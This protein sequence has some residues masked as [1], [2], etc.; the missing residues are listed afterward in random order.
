MEGTAGSD[1]FIRKI[2]RIR[3]ISVVAMLTEKQDRAVA[4]IGVQCH[5]LAG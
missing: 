2:T 3:L 4:L 1:H 5:C